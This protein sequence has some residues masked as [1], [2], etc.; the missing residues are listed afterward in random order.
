MTEW[1]S[2]SLCGGHGSCVE[3]GRCRD[4]HVEVRN[5]RYPQEFLAFNPSEWAEFIAAVKAGEF[6]LGQLP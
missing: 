4:G 2:S 5:S 6:D 1:K 3:V